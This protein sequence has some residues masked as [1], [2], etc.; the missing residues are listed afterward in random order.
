MNGDSLLPPSVAIVS[1]A[2]IDFDGRDENWI[3]AQI[4]W[5]E[6]KRAH[7]RDDAMAKTNK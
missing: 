6:M 3:E 1:I 5:S 7:Q 4:D 2:A